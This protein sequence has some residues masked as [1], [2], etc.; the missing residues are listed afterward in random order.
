MQSLAVITAGQK[1]TNSADPTQGSF[2][3]RICSFCNDPELPAVLA[4]ARAHNRKPYVFFWKHQDQNYVGAEGSEYVTGVL[5]DISASLYKNPQ[6]SRASMYRCLVLIISI[7]LFVLLLLGLGAIAPGTPQ[8]VFMVFW[9]IAF[10]AFIFCG[11]FRVKHIAEVYYYR[12]QAE[13]VE[14]IR[15]RE[16]T[17]PHVRFRLVHAGWALVAEVQEHGE[18]AAHP[19]EVHINQPSVGSKFALKEQGAKKVKKPA[20]NDDHDITDEE[21]ESEQHRS[22]KFDN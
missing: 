9:I 21:K 7:L 16:A 12:R 10:I 19:E 5:A 4:S 8:D 6:H 14:I 13:M 18:F 3:S 22:I 2:L 20:G 17:A 11:L 15:K 1:Q